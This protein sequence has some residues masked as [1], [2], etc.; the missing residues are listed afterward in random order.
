MLEEASNKDWERSPIGRY[1]CTASSVIWVASPVLCGWQLWGRPDDTETRTILRLIDRYPVMPGTFRAVADTRKVELVSPTALPLLVQWYFRHRAEL[2][3][4]ID[5]QAN[6][7]RRDTIGFL[8]V[9]IVISMGDAFPSASFTEPQDAFRAVAG[10]AGAALCDEVEAIAERVR[11][12]PREIQVLRASLAS[13]PDTTI[14][15]VAKELHISRRSLQRA[16]GRSGTSFHDEVTTARFEAARTLLTA[17]DAKIAS[18]AAR[19]GWS[20][21]TL[22][23]VFRT[24]TGLTPADWRKR[25]PR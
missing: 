5:L 6:V 20:E 12:M 10:D 17:P 18:V 23:T 13:N 21:R 22:T 7:I 8:L 25:E 3:R 1:T 24:R 15:M 11:S 16:L 4:K 2:K 9:G 19:V 14:E